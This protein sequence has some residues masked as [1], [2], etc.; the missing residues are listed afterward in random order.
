MI[1]RT[2]KVLGSLPVC[3]WDF[4]VRLAMLAIGQTPPARCVVF[5]YHGVNA[6]HR[7]RF[8]R[9]MDSLLR[10]A[11]PVAADIEEPLAA[12]RRYAAVTFDDGFVSVVQNALPEL[13]SRQIPLT[14][15]VPTGSLGLEPLWIRDAKSPA[16]FETVLSEEDLRSLKTLDLVTI[17][18]HSV[19]HPN[20][21]K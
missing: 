12:G 13:R 11:Q 14:F 7:E 3:A 15:F 21:V 5:Y 18:S 9:Q 8:A 6:K 16:K 1:V 4:L 10:L 2:L 17:G 20:F 19:S